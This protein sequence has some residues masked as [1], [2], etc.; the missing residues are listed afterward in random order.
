[1]IFSAS[2]E[3]VAS[4]CIA[5]CLPCVILTAEWRLSC[6]ADRGAADVSDTAVGQVIVRTEESQCSACVSLFRRT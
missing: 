3:S 4:Q 5:V 2:V 6:L 1:M